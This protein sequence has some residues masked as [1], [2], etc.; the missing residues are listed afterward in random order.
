M[1]NDLLQ[2]NLHKNNLCGILLSDGDNMFIGRF[3]ETKEIKE[4]LD[5]PSFEAIIL[6]GRRRVGKTEIIKESIKDIK[7]PIVNYECKKTSASFN[8]EMLTKLLVE[9]FNYGPLKFESFDDFFA[10]IFKESLGKEFILIIDE[11]SFL[12][13]EDFSIESSLARAIDK[14]K[15]ESKLKVI[16]SGS[17]VNL[18]SKMIEY[19]SHSYGRFNHIL[20]IRPFDYYL[21]SYFYPNYSNEDKIKMFSVFGGV[22]YFNS[23]INPNKSAEEN[24]INLLVKKDSILEHEIS[25]M[26]L[27]E[28]NKINLLNDLIGIIGSGTIKYKDIVSKLNQYNGSRPDYLLNKL[29]DMN[30]IRKVTPIN[31][32]NNKKKMYYQFED[33]LIHFYYKYIF[34]N[35]FT[36]N[37]SDPYFFYQRFIKEDFEKEYIPKKFERI[38]M[39]FLLKCNFKGIIKETI[40]DIGTY[41]FDDVKNRMNREFDVVTKDLNGY[42]SYECKY[43]NSAITNKIIEEEIKQTQNLDIH[44]YK[45]GFISKSGFSKDVDKEKY[46]CFCLSDFYK[47][48][49]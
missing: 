15:N 25:E 36:I 10:F 29:I 1:Q 37:R 41:S 21:S 4:A 7:M 16:I 6:Y 24:I 17:Y 13:E 5:S 34:N 33:N 35:P 38:S 3:E 26:I 31:D 46:N 49:E 43:T 11:F 32:K 28:T 20:A 12:L 47:D 39:D 19:G 45:L 14:Y 8:L 22:P 40:M 18:M 9:T 27:A 30:I 48:N 42:I 44:F 23:F 2:N